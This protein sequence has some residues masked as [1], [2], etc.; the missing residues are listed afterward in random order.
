MSGYPFNPRASVWVRLEEKRRAKAASDRSDARPKSPVEPKREQEALQAPDASDADDETRTYRGARELTFEREA[1]YN[2]VWST[3]L[4]TLGPQCGLSD[5]GLRKICKAMNIPVPP[6]GYW[7]KVAAGQKV[8]RARLPARA[9]RTSFVSRPPPAREHVTVDDASWLK[10]RLGFERRPE[11]RIVELTEGAAWHPA[12]AQLEKLLT[13]AE[14]GRQ[15]AVANRDLAEARRAKQRKPIPH[16]NP[17]EYRW[18]EDGLL[19][20]PL[21]SCLRVSELSG[22][23]ALRIANAIFVAAAARG[24]TAEL[25]SGRLKLSLM[26]ATFSMSIRERQDF[27]LVVRHPS[28][29]AFG[30]A[31]K[32]KPTDRLALHVKRDRL[33]DFT[34]ADEG[35]KRLEDQLNL[36]FGRV[37]R[38]VVLT[39]ERAKKEVAD[40]ER[41]QARKIRAEAIWRQHAIEAEARAAEAERQAKLLDEAA[42][43]HSAQQV[44]AYIEA[45][46]PPSAVTPG[47]LEWRRWALEV[48][49]K[50]DP[51]SSRRAKLDVSSGRE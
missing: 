48:A 40:R 25:D 39:R 24:C 22:R 47:A 11:N 20:E 45:L 17:L 3:P 38:T 46:A 2:E 16:F 19:G 7:A 32:F 51:S 26:E 36:L 5:N 21:P 44:R 33:G 43:W 41:E 42:K 29:P 50:L 9:P 12:I 14:R 15:K 6:L 28:I 23:R 35:G 18:L 49:A 10:E 27:D 30:K 13:A 37:Y 4:S 8:A 31:K 34:L 1:L